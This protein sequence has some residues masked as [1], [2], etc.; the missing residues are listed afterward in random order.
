LDD[1]LWFW[2]LLQRFEDQKEEIVKAF[3]LLESRAMEFFIAHG[4]P[5]IFRI[6]DSNAK[7]FAAET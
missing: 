5:L 2:A 3:Q 4:W 1:W 6:I 7:L